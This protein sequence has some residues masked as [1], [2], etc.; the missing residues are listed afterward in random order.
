MSKKEEY[1][2]YI[3]LFRGFAILVI[4]GIHC[5]ISFGWPEQSLSKDILITLLDNGTVLF[6]FIAGFLFQYLRGKYDYTSYLQRK[7]KYVIIPYI[8]V[9][10]PAIALDLYVN[11]TPVWL[12]ENLIDQPK[13]VH[14]FYMIVTGKHLGPF[15]F[16]P[17]ITVFYL[18]SPILLK[19][20]NLIF[21]K[22]VFPVLFLAGLFTYRFG[23]FSNT[24]DSFLH[25]F[26]VYIY[27]MWASHY[28]KKLINM[29]SRWLVF[30][31]LIYLFLSALEIINIIDVP[32]LS[33]FDEAATAPFF[34]FNIAKL[35]VSILC[36]ILLKIFYMLNKDILIF[37]YLGNYSF[38]IYFI[39]LY[40][41]TAIER[42]I[43]II[44]PT[45]ELNLITFILYLTA[46]TLFSVFIVYF[47]KR[48][49]KS[50]SRL[51]IGS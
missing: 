16:I 13:I 7:A 17:M 47:A 34:Y 21:Y 43:N 39:H 15:W 26:P 44:D 19:L 10:I 23:Y 36:V 28:R 22:T 50:N 20:D 11:P 27:G 33:S 9:S 32:R 1:L 25:F 38:G 35:K 3:H 45:F 51:L 30:L 2:N 8:L 40:I 4:V 46:V 6:V 49:F 31:V 24:L 29:R 14:A 12:P 37:K 42:V 18:V 41:I 48:I 5:R